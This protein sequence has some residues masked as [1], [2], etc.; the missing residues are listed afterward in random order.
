[1]KHTLSRSLSL[2]L[3]LSLALAPV[4][5]ASM[6]L[7]T[8]V[9]DTVS[10]LAPGLTTTTQ[11]LWSAAFSDLRTE[12]YLSYTP[13]SSVRPVV[14]YGNTVL[15]K[16]TLTKM[17]K[18]LETATGQRVVG[19][20]NGDFFSLATGDPIGLLVT[21]GI[22]RSSSSY[23]FAAGFRSDG[24]AFVGQPQL[25]IS[26]SVAGKNFGIVDMNKTRDADG[27]YLYTNDFGKTTRHTRAGVDVILR[28]LTTNIEAATAESAAEKRL[29]D[30]ALAA[31][32]KHQADLAAGVV[33]PDPAIPP[34]EPPVFNPTVVM[35]T[36]TLPLNLQ[37][38]IGKGVTYVV[39]QVLHSTKA[40]DIPQGRVVITVSGGCDA[41]TIAK[42]SAL[43]PGDVMKLNFSTADPRWNEAVSAIGGVAQIVTDGKVSTT[44]SDGQA[45]RTALGVK[46]D[47]STVLYTIDGRQ[48]GYSVGATTTQVAER[49]V[50]LG[51]VSA[52]SLDGGGSTMFGTTGAVEQSFALKN[53]P[54]DGSQRAVTNALFFVSNLAP[55]GLPGSLALVP[56][57]G[58]LLSGATL[59]L[60]AVTIDTSHFPM[61]DASDVS[62]TA[63]GSG[64]ITGNLLTAGTT[65]GNVTVTAG[66]SGVSGSATY[67][68]I[69]TP[70]AISV[71]DEASGQVITTLNANPQG[72]TNLSATA[73]YYNLPLIGGDKCFTWSVT[74][75]LGTITPD[76]L[77]TAGDQGGSG[78]ISVSAGGK[79]V[80]IA[81]TIAS[82][83]LTLE[84]FEGSLGQITNSDTAQVTLDGKTVKYGKQSLK[85]SYNAGGNLLASL[86]L[87]IAIPTGEEYL[88]LWVYG[89]GSGTDLTLITADLAGTPTSTYLGTLGFQGWQQLSLRLPVG[90]AA[91]VALQMSRADGIPTAG[92]LYLDQ[93]TTSNRPLT[94]GTTP[95]ITLKL[96]DNAVTAAVLDNVDKK[97][98]KENV[99][100]SFDGR[101]LDFTW[102]PN[103]LALTATLPAYDGTLHRVSLTVTDASGNIGKSGID[104]A[105]TDK[106]SPP[107]FTDITGHWSENYAR[108]L[109]QRGISNGVTTDAGVLYQP[110]KDITRGEFFVMTARWM[111]L[112]LEEYSSVELP[113][114]DA[115]SIPAWAMNGVKAM[116]SLGVVSG[117][118]GADGIFVRSGAT[119]TRAEAMAVLGRLQPRGFHEPA[120]TYTDAAAIP[121]WAYTHISSLTGQGV[122][123][124]SDGA[125]RPGAPVTRGEVAKLLFTMS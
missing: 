27:Y 102:N 28:P 63:A 109:Y 19:G 8:E 82:H 9:S 58:L 36:E 74:P 1:M 51:C 30:T 52:L 123:S 46:A 45:P 35:P 81:V 120:L 106:T 34:V 110:N 49:L 18:D 15:Q 104:I 26:G 60:K 86:S 41:A 119:I 68:V 78:T 3:A 91:L 10:T 98:P 93:L 25:V 103:T 24:T 72:T 97:I 83:I 114:T 88:N 116:Y 96:K 105:P 101:P 6:A 121:A 38:I 44:L 39:E 122:V 54:S 42:L 65:P 29:F 94:D 95:A 90:T 117:S 20:T 12:R 62:F 85:I 107:P 55:T 4:A 71:K 14:V 5:S 48:K 113:F 125:V 53:K 84:S 111:G 11:S 37:P 99:R 70:T 76:G 112:N 23:N 115:A 61:G 89:D 66:G 69:S 92:T 100:L 79:T 77:F 7:G 21:D 43:V 33:V 16:G 50:E 87:P 64:A 118:A 13:S 31:Y 2:I 75:G 108:F 124:G 40:I 73:L 56:E 32:E 47:G 59:P 22:V 57:G 17:A 80:S 67:N